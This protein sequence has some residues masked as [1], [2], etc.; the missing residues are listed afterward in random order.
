MFPPV[1]G[2]FRKAAT[3]I[4]YGGYI[5]PKGWQIFWVTSMTHMDNN[6]FPEPSK[7]DPSRFENQ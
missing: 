5:I 7:F 6:I 4:E 2:G 3:D 1:F